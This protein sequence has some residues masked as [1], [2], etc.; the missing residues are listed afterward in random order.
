[1]IDFAGSV[2]NFSGRADL[3]KYV[4]FL[5]G[6]SLIR[7]ISQPLN[8]QISLHFCDGIE[9]GPTDSDQAGTRWR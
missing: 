5:D 3:P 1:M 4:P 9:S 6:V 2:D 8:G 7:H